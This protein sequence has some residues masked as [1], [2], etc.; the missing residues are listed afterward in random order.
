MPYQDIYPGTHWVNG[1]EKL[2]YLDTLTLH[3]DNATARIV[4]FDT[5]NWQAYYPQELLDAGCGGP[6]TYGTDKAH[7]YAFCDFMLIPPYE[8]IGVL[9]DYPTYQEC[10]TV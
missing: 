8:Q 7:Y 5:P 6:G 4:E 2:N 9:S 1:F 10:L 3:R